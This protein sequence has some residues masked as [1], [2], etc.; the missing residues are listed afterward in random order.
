MLSPSS[1]IL[2]SASHIRQH[3]TTPHRT[4]WDGIVFFSSLLYL[5]CT[6]PLFASTCSLSPLFSSPSHLRL[7]K[8]HP[9]PSVCVYVCLFMLVRIVCTYTEEHL[10]ELFGRHGEINSVKVMDDLN[11]HSSF[12]FFSSFYQSFF[13]R[14][15]LLSLHICYSTCSSIPSLSI[16]TFPNTTHLHSIRLK[17]EICDH[18]GEK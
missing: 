14:F 13:F 17:V 1:I 6:Y 3:P 8:K 12:Y 11:L 5:H 2:I 16:S 15:H 9:N 10:F 7:T 18:H 4:T